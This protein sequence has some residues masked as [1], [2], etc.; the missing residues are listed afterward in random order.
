M[1]LQVIDGGK[2]KVPEWLSW[3][4]SDETLTIDGVKFCRE[5]F[6]MFAHMEPG[7]MF[8]C[9]RKENGIVT[10]QVESG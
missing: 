6:S 4:P 10:L 5:F 7:Q 9:G 8:V 1:A 2:G 3:N